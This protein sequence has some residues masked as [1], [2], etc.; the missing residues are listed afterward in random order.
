MQKI[1]HIK[2]LK[3]GDLIL[4]FV[5]GIAHYFEVI[6]LSKHD[7]DVVYIT[8]DHGHAHDLHQASIED[9]T[10]DWFKNFTSISILRYRWGYY[11]R[12]MIECERK[13]RA[14]KKNNN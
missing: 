12:M 4:T 14:I 5:N 11:S 1:K 7:P 6:A 3:V 8:D 9:D 2:E 13:I 10:E